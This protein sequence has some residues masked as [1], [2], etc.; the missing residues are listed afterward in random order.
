MEV[1][2]VLKG[3]TMGDM[4]ATYTLVQDLLR[5]DVMTAFNNEQATFKEQTL[6]NLEHCLNTVTVQ[7]LPN[8]AYKLQK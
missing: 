2:Q 4:D 7:V 1:K 6:E 5:G 3:Q 8:K